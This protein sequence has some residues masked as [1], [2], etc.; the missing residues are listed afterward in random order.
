[1]RE[2]P[3]ALRLPGKAVGAQMQG[4]QP[5]PSMVPR[6]GVKGSL[7]REP[8]L[9]PATGPSTKKEKADN[10]SQELNKTREGVTRCAGSDEG[11][12]S[13]PLCGHPPCG[14]NPDLRGEV[15]PATDR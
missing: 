1:M 3:L 9:D 11:K 12:S 15:T 14:V 2:S 4:P 10:E 6:S 5:F 7:R 13:R 8:A